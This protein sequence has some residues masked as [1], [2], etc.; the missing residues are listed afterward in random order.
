[1]QL[2]KHYRQ[3]GPG[4]V[5]RGYVYVNN[6]YVEIDLNGRACP[7]SPPVVGVV[8]VLLHFAHD[9]LHIILLLVGP[10]PPRP[11]HQNYT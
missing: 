5:G 9:K 7:R 11:L 10:S 3:G 1:M 2:S 6:S 8:N 4:R